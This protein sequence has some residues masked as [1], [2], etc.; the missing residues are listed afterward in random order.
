[1]ANPVKILGIGITYLGLGAMFLMAIIGSFSLDLLLVYFVSKFGNNRGSFLNNFIIS[2]FLWNI[3]LSNRSSLYENVGFSLL[4]SPII[5]GLSVGLSFAL[6]APEFG[7][8]I[9]A[10]WG[11][12]AAILIIGL[13]VY[14][15]GNLL[16]SLFSWMTTPRYNAEARFS[17]ANDSLIAA[18]RE[19]NNLRDSSNGN[20]YGG[21]QQSASASRAAN[22]ESWETQVSF[23][24]P[25]AAPRR[26]ESAPAYKLVDDNAV[27]GYEN[28]PGYDDQVVPS[29]PP[30]YG[31]NN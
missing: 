24:S 30:A 23:G 9:L 31:H 8:A 28:P 20:V 21:V 5:S 19:L 1:M 14:S 17:E 29:A 12:A 13:T 15:T 10:G 3:M 2:M 26:D 25:I 11:G 22:Q 7:L 4:A 16:G 27:P 6:G 18:A